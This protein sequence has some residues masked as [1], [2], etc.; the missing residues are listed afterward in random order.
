MKN[1]IKNEL[2]NLG[3]KFISNDEKLLRIFLETTPSNI[4]EIVIIPT[5]KK[6][7]KKLVDKLEN[8]NI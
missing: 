1:S 3:L 7:M 6:V 8:K 5:I 4:N 2:L